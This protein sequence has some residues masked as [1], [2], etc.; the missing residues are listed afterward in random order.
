MLLGLQKGFLQDMSHSG[1]QLSP[2][3]ACDNATTSQ[4]LKLHP[5]IPI[6]D[7]VMYLPMYKD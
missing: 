4:K 1:L 7:N 6:R 5:A 2:R 3:A